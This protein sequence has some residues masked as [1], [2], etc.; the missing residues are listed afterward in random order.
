MS[1]E[2]LFL[3][4]FKSF[5]EFETWFCLWNY[6]NK[7]VF[8]KAENLEVF[9][10]NLGLNFEQVFGNLHSLLSEQIAVSKNES[11]FTSLLTEE[12]KEEKQVFVRNKIFHF[13]EEVFV[14]T[15]FYT[16]EEVFSKELTTDLYNTHL[17]YQIILSSNFEYIYFNPLYRLLTNSKASIGKNFF[18]IHQ[19]EE[20]LEC[21]KNSFNTSK[22]YF[23]KNFPIKTHSQTQYWDIFVKKI[24]SR[25]LNQ[26]CLILQFVDQTENFF[27]RNRERINQ[28][29]YYSIFDAILD[30][31]VCIDSQGRI[32]MVNESLSRM[33]EYE[34][35]EL[36]YKNM[37]LLMPEEIAVKHD[38]YLQNYMMGKGRG[39]IV[40][41]IREV[42][43]KKKSGE[44]F[45]IELKVAEFPSSEYSRFFVGVIRDLTYE[46]KIAKLIQEK[47]QEIYRLHNME[48]LGKMSA[49]IIHDISNFLQPLLLYAEMA[50]LEVRQYFSEGESECARE[51]LQNLAK[52]KEF[53]LS[54]KNFTNEILNFTKS[55]QPPKEKIPFAHHAKEILEMF[56][57]KHRDCIFHLDIQDSNKKVF[58]SN[59]SIFQIFS[60]L[61]TNSIQAM[62]ENPSKEIFVTIK[63]TPIDIVVFPQY[64]HEYKE[65]FLVEFQDTGRGIPEENL[66]KIFEPFFTTKEKR[67]RTRAFNCK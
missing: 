37:N 5:F 34:S 13:E 26:D 64:L 30:G 63:E 47:E 43:G 31:I 65:M 12:N 52:V 14:L 25:F 42:Q 67:N 16:L 27:F 56:K 1:Q 17:V 22:E 35:F 51:V 48:L 33:F 28:S 2:E 40:N 46:K 62:E 10:S 60:N 9:L 39:N 61:V 20:L 59:E 36:I 23:L 21:F 7:E 6:L 49:G 15:E 41:N 8:L 32:L 4:L 66:S 45:P 57:V 55:I 29:L 19:S 18:E 11:H 24:Y 58:I 44:I 54:I 38:E 3:K 53:A 50:E